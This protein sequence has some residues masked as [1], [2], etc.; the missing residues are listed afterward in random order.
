VKF[1]DM[2]GVSA[3]TRKRLYH[4]RG[5]RVPG[6]HGGGANCSLKCNTGP[7]SVEKQMVCC[8]VGKWLGK[9]LTE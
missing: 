8:S 3:P 1:M 9:S 4:T 2:H 7:C 5:G 6:H